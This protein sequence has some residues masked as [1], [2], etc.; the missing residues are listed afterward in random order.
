[1]LYHSDEKVRLHAINT[2]DY[3]D[4]KALPILESIKDKMND[5]ANYVIRVTKKILMDFMKL[6]NE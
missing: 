3:L 5:D 2:I 6:S 1:M 4:E